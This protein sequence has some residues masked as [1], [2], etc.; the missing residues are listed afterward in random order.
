MFGDDFFGFVLGPALEECDQGA[1]GIDDV[2]DLL[3]LD[4]AENAVG[5][6][7]SGEA[8][9][10][11]FEVL[12]AAEAP[13]GAVKIEVVAGADARGGGF[14]FFQAFE[15][16]EELCL[17][18]LGEVVAGET[19]AFGFEDQADAVDLGDVV[20]F[21]ED[22]E[23]TAAG[24]VHNEALLLEMLE[25]LADGGAGDLK[26]A[27]ELAFVE[28]FARFET[29]AEDGVGDDLGDVLFERAHQHG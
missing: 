1:M 19:E 6:E 4:D 27:G 8:V 2:A 26:V 25:C 28:T 20:V 5:E 11:P 7:R 21:E 3:A 17:F 24:A 15:E 18:G 14:A 29:A 12:I 13:D 23:H 10:G 16:L 9:K 22:D